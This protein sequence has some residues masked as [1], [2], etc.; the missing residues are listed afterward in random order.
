M[1][2]FDMKGALE[3]LKIFINE[4]KDFVLLQQP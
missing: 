1:Q 3:D 2:S 4:H